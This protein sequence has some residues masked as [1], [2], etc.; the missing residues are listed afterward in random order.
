MWAPINTA[1]NYVDVT[2]SNDRIPD[3]ATLRASDFA[4]DS[5]TRQFYSAS[6]YPIGG[7]KNSY[8]FYVWGTSSTSAAQTVSFDASGNAVIRDDYYGNTLYYN[9][10]ATAYFAYQTSAANPVQLTAG[11]ASKEVE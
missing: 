10:A 9:N 5:G 3:S 1:P 8:Y 7:Y 6:G 11:A 2:I 4:Y